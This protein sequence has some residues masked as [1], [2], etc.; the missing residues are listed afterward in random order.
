MKPSFLQTSITCFLPNHMRQNEGGGHTFQ[1]KG[2]EYYWY[3]YICI[4]SW[5]LQPPTFLDVSYTTAKTPGILMSAWGMNG[6]PAPQCKVRLLES[7][8]YHQPWIS[9][10]STLHIGKIVQF[11]SVRWGHLRTVNWS[12]GVGW[13]FFLLKPNPWLVIE[14]KS[15]V[16]PVDWKSG[17]WISCVKVG[18]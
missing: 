4:R 16:G 10:E 8:H 18:T 2:N 9:L 13:D 6:K 14:N 7:A 3:L 15:G 12:L 1:W 17:D 5:V 11:C